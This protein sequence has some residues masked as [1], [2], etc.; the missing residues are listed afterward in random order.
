MR[1]P[2]FVAAAAATAATA[3]AGCGG[4]AKVQ[5]STTPAHIG[6][7]NA[8]APTTPTGA[9]GAAPAGGASGRFTGADVPTRYGDIQVALTLQHGHIT[10]VQWLKLPFDRPRSQFISQQAAPI[11]RSEVLAAQSANI[12]LLSGATYTSDAWATSVQAALS[13]VH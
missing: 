3:T 13:Q 4:N 11:L 9:T 8:G 7:S 12:N 6:T 10:D 1:H 5:R 2:A